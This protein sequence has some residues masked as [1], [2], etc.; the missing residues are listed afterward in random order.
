MKAVDAV[1]AL[2][3]NRPDY[4]VPAATVLQNA[5]TSYLGKTRNKV[6]ALE[7]IEGGFT[8]FAAGALDNYTLLERDGTHMSL[9]LGRYLM[10]SAVFYHIVNFFGGI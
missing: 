5:R 9:E 2:D 3:E 4:I 1:K 7:L 10:G 6:D 8:D